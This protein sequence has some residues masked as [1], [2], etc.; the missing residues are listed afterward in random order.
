MAKIF[1]EIHARSEKPDTHYVLWLEP[2][3]KSYRFLCFKSEEHKWVAVDYKAEWSEITGMPK[4][5][6]SLESLKEFI[7]STLV[8]DEVGFHY[9]GSVPAITGLAKD[10]EREYAW[11]DETSKELLPSVDAVLEKIISKVWFE[12]TTVSL[13]PKPICNDMYVGETFNGKTVTVTIKNMHDGSNSG[14]SAEKIGEATLD[15]V[16]KDKSQIKLKSFTPSMS[17]RHGVKVTVNTYN[18]DGKEIKLTED[19]AFNSYYPY[20]VWTSESK[21][22]ILPTSLSEYKNMLKGDFNFVFKKNSELYYNI[23][24]PYSISEATQANTNDWKG[25]F[26]KKSS[27]YN[28]GRRNYYWFQTTDAVRSTSDKDIKVVVKL[29]QYRD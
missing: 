20:Y 7:N 24:V 21:E 14:W 4:E 28:V 3:E 9:D 26:V 23:L 15:S 16:D 1:R 6:E 13:S 17:K 18:S 5:F 12:D 25:K 11:G 19:T 8:A 2:T 22:T 10:L 27:N 29:E